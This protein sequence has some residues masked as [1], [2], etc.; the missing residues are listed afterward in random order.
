M[1]S[2]IIIVEFLVKILVFI[3]LRIYHIQHIRYSQAGTP[4]VKVVSSYDAEACTF[5][6][7][8]RFGSSHV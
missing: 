8:F 4:V 1:V 6:L 7:K 2:Q 3:L 5:S